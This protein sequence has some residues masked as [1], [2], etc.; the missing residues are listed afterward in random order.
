MIGHAIYSLG[1][2]SR[3]NYLQDGVIELGISDPT[4]PPEYSLH[5]SHVL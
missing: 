5:E 3:G 2:A 4:P 1:G